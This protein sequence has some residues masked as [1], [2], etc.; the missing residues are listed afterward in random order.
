MAR[1]VKEATGA[2]VLAAGLKAGKTV[3][4]WIARLPTK[5]EEKKSL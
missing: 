4:T 2:S 3:T 1:E 5:K